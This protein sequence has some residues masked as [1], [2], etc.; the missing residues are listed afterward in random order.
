MYCHVIPYAGT[1]I[2]LQRIQS[3]FAWWKKI[4]LVVEPTHLKTYA[5]QIGSFPQVEVNIKNNWNHHLEILDYL[6]LSKTGHSLV[7][8][9]NLEP[10]CWNLSGGL[11]HTEFLQKL[12]PFQ[13][14]QMGQQ[15][16]SMHN[17]LHLDIA[18]CK[19]YSV[20]FFW[21]VLIWCWIFTPPK[22]DFW[23]FPRFYYQWGVCFWA[24]Q[25]NPPNSNMGILGVVPFIELGFR[26]HESWNLLIWTRKTS[27]FLGWNKSS[28]TNLSMTPKWN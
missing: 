5:R 2:N 6:L 12:F 15:R 26:P 10:M 16:N 3:Q 13:S 24:N 20:L 7:S 17:C 9:W 19:K 25:K 11:N 1:A 27:D 22:K 14:I 4:W 28:V 18:L 8:T 23:D 21:L